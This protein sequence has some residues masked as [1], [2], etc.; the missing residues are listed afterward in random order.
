MRTVAAWKTLGS[1]IIAKAPIFSIRKVRRDPPWEADS[2][3]FFV[4]DLPNW[5]NVIA[6][7]AEDEVVLIEQYRHGTDTITIEIPGGNVDSEESFLDAARRELE[8]ET[9]Y[10]SDDWVELGTVDPNPAIQSNRCV[11]Y[12]AR[13]AELRGE[14]GFDEH[15]AIAI[16]LTPLAALDRLFNDGLITH[17]LVVAAFDHLR[18]FSGVE[19]PTTLR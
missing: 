4:V 9:G 14:L 10:V 16:S 15:E 8:E 12:L 7:T 13:G 2:A 18:R 17:A 1:E 11:T 3:E 19:L 6:V 5:V